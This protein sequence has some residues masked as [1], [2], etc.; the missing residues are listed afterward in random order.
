MKSTLNEKL[1]TIIDPDI[2]SKNTILDFGCGQGELLHSIREK[3]PD[4]RL[5]GIDSDKNSIYHAKSRFDNIDFRCY[6][7][8]NILDFENETIDIILSVD[9]LEC[10][11]DKE[12]LQNEIYRILKP[13]GKVLFAHWDWDTQVY[14]SS[15][16]DSMRKLVHA[17]TDW[18][19][20]WMDT[21]DGT[22]GRK[23]WG[24]FNGTNKFKG[25]IDIF[26]LIETEFVKGKYG[27]DRLHDLYEI[28]GT[29][30]VDRTELDLIIFEMNQLYAT[31][32]YMYSLNSY[33][34]YGKK[35][36]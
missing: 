16:V 26:N 8:K 6:K 31:N 24:Y 32:Q 23:L 1:F 33:I 34:Y 12:V 17:F 28:A 25:T 11:E 7:F 13:T 18:K 2:K 4:T 19:Q 5:I 27:F 14:N 10:V 29:G 30:I 15:N 21:N 35:V 36:M 20:N 22:M 9:T 3:H